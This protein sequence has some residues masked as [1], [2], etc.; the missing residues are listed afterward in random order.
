MLGVSVTRVVRPILN[1][2]V[3]LF[4]CEGWPVNFDRGF[5]L[6]HLIQQWGCLVWQRTHCG[7]RRSLWGMRPAGD[8]RKPFKPTASSS[9]S[10]I[11]NPFSTNS[12]IYVRRNEGSLLHELCDPYAMAAA[13]CSGVR[14]VPSILTGVPFWCGPGGL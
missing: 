12:L 10:T 4:R 8:K 14:G 1:G 6:A 9:E 7:S 2:R 11:Q 13:S 3:E 5:F